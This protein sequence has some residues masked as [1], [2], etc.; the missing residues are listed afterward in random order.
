MNVGEIMKND[1][2]KMTLEEYIDRYSKKENTKAIKTGLFIFEGSIG[3]LIFVLLFLLT[4]KLFDIHQYAGYAGCALSVIIFLSLY[5]IPIIKL[6]NTKAFM[7]NI[8]PKNAISAKKYNK[9]LREN[10]ADKMIDL[11]AKTEGVTWYDSNKIG[12]LAIC[13]HQHDDKGLKKCLTEIYDTDIRKA[14]NKMIRDASLK[15][16]FTTALSQSEKLDTLFVAVYNLNLI[17]NIIYLYGYRPSDAKLLRIYQTVMTNSLI[18]YGVNGISTNMAAGLVK[19]MGKVV[20]DIPV[21]GSAIGTVID[22]SIQGV[23]NAS[24][25]VIIGYQTKLYLKKEYHLQD[26]LDEIDLSDE[27]DEVE[28][29]EMLKDVKEEVSNKEN[30]KNAKLQTA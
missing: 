7:T 4:M 2:N 14:C 12:R 6:H 30:L 8:S 10:I 9:E 28:A 18:A 16:G 25:T 5:L 20:T 22:S 21:L 26:L 15:I 1:N 19:K 23:I 17:K 3:L 13:R 11:E 29:K 24:M 27:V